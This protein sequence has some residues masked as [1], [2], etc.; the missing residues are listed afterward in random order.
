MIDELDN[1]R[2]DDWS[3]KLT[4]L[5]TRQRRASEKGRSVLETHSKMQKTNN[6]NQSIQHESLGL[7]ANKKTTVRE[8]LN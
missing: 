7:A 8:N 5:D 2:G 3:E 1:E 6:S 4:T